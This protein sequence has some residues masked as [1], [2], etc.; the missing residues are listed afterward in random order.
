VRTLNVILKDDDWEGLSDEIGIGYVPSSSTEH[1]TGNA[2]LSP[3][4]RDPSSIPQPKSSPFG[5]FGTKRAD[6]PAMEFTSLG[7]TA[8]RLTISVPP[9]AIVSRMFEKEVICSNSTLFQSSHPSRIINEAL[10]EMVRLS[11]FNQ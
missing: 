10:L 2:S 9:A 7:T 8:N 11:L 1:G 5:N 3:S 6:G 4:N